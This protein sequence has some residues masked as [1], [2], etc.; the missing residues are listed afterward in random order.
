MT[1]SIEIKCEPNGLEEVDYYADKIYPQA[2]ARETL[3]MRILN[4]T[5]ESTFSSIPSGNPEYNPTSMHRWAL[6][7]DA[8]ASV[9]PELRFS[10]SSNT[11]VIEAGHALIESAHVHPVSMPQNSRPDSLFID[12]SPRSRLISQIGPICK[13]GVEWFLKVFLFIDERSPDGIPWSCWYSRGSRPYRVN[14]DPE[15][16]VP[17]SFSEL[18]PNAP[19]PSIILHENI[20][21]NYLGPRY[22]TG[23]EPFQLYCWSASYMEDWKW[24]HRVLDPYTLAAEQSLIKLMP[25]REDLSLNFQLHGEPP[26]KAIQLEWVRED[27][28]RSLLQL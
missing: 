10:N 7:S 5:S 18:D 26:Y 1:F 2:T 8:S 14:E 25:E 3:E 21:Y 22:D 23:R 11:N 27:V 9:Y 15:T 28:R 19:I 12:E 6:Q 4:P 17:P 16:P 24:G 13:D 20:R